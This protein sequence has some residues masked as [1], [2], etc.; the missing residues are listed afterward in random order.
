MVDPWGMAPVLSQPSLP[1]PLTASH[2]R[3]LHVSDE[4]LDTIKTRA[5]KEGQCVLGLRFSDDKMSPPERFERLRD[6]LG[7]NFEGIEID[8]S[9][10][11]PYG[12]PKMAHSVVTTDLIDEDGQPTQAAL[13]RVIRFFH[14]NLDGPA[15]EKSVE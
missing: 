3:A 11:N 2:K 4:D 14:E 8:S 10:D 15:T 9:K 6:E 12:N 13:A 1:F 7:E 5:I